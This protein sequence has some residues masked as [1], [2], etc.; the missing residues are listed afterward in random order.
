MEA[1]IIKITARSLTH[2]YQNKTE[3]TIPWTV[4]M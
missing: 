2:N 1:N 4:L 3:T